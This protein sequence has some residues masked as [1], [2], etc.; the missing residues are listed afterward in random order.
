MIAV[1]LQTATT[2]TALAT[3]RV[4]GRGRNVL[5]A[6]NLHAGPGQGAEG[7]LSTRA[8]RLRAVACEFDVSDQSSDRS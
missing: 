8:W 7:G 6:A 1:H 2:A 5:N 3:S 4:V